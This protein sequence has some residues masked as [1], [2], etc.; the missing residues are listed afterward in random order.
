MTWRLCIAI[1][2]RRQILTMGLW[3][4]QTRLSFVTVYRHSTA[5]NFQ[6]SI[7][8]K[9]LSYA[10]AFS[11]VFGAG[12]MAGTCQ[13]DVAKIDAALKTATLDADVKTEVTDLRE[14]AIQLCGAGNDKEGLDVTAQA[15][16]LL[17]IE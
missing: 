3:W 8:I 7:M 11:M 14:Q 15:K 12:A 6:E 9:T 13:D 2:Q 17:S 4:P 5:I 1:W 10:A 16:T